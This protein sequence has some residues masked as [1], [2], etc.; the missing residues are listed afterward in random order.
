MSQT[1]S[2]RREQLD[3]TVSMVCNLHHHA[4]ACRDAEQTRHFYEDVLGMPMIAAVQESTRSPSGAQTAYLHMFFEMADGTCLAFFDFPDYY[5]GIDASQLEP[6]D[7]LVHHIALEVHGYDKIEA[8]KQRLTAQGVALREIDHGYCR[9]LYFTDPNGLKLELTTN[10]ANS[11]GDFAVFRRD[12]RTT[13]AQWQKFKSGELAT[14]AATNA[15]RPSHGS[16]RA[17]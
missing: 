15:A 3:P 11:P 14:L 7:S 4:F 8:F 10:V 13:L 9:S 1:L 2:L 17:D 5:A 16:A 12:A 6:R